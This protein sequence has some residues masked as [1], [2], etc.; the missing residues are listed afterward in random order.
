MDWSADKV[1]NYGGM[2][3]V[4]LDGV[5]PLPP[6]VGEAGHVEQEVAAEEAGDS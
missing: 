2:T 5:E 4:D 3:G 6:G 1:L